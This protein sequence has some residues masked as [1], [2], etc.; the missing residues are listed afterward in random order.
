LV[1]LKRYAGR[2]EHKEPCR[3]SCC[4]KRYSRPLSRPESAQ[5]SRVAA[6]Q[7]KGP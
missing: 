4:V 1:R 6:L 7:L 2:S 5:Q 3:R